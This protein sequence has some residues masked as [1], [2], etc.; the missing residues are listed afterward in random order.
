MKIL[1]ILIREFVDFMLGVYKKMNNN[2]MKYS[3]FFIV[4]MRVYR[5]GNRKECNI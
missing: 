1:L 4:C 2:G 5:K 3:I